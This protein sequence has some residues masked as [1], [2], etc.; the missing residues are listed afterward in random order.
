VG[1]ES[2]SRTWSRDSRVADDRNVL[3]GGDASRSHAAKVSG[4][5]AAQ[6]PVSIEI[7]VA[8]LKWY[9]EYNYCDMV[10][11]SDT[12]VRGSLVTGQILKA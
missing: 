10:Q 6:Y 8:G 5:V 4:K 7:V 2:G 9:P 3:T 11:L 12:K 1:H